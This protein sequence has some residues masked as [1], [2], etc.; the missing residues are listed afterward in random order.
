MTINR[1]KLGVLQEGTASATFSLR[2]RSKMR[3]PESWC[4]LLLGSGRPLAPEARLHILAVQVERLD[5]DAAVEAMPPPRRDQPL[6]PSP[7]CRASPQR[8][9]QTS[10][11]SQAAV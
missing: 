5:N 1:S 11:P 6:L 8:T 9:S 10:L 4:L 2:S 7:Q 3:G